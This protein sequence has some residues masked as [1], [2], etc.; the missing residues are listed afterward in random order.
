[1]HETAA[2]QVLSGDLVWLACSLGLLIVRGP[3]KLLKTTN[4][5]KKHIKNDHPP[6]IISNSRVQV[7][8]GFDDC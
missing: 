8:V 7:L 5:I 2:C 1:M 4:M 3:R 6:G